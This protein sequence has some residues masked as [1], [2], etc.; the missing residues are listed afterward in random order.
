MDDLPMAPPNVLRN[1]T[2]P[3]VGIGRRREK[4]TK[5]VTLSSPRRP[6][7]RICTQHKRL[8]RKVRSVKAEK[9]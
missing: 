1:I 5:P 6:P 8:E 2:F 9:Y 4:L 7:D 3:L